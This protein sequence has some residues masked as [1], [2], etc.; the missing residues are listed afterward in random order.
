MTQEFLNLKNIFEVNGV[1]DRDSLAQILSLAN[2]GLNYVPQTLNNKNYYV[3]LKT[4][5]ES[6]LKYPENQ[7]VYEN[8]VE[9]IQAYIYDINIQKVS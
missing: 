1:I 9:K 5:V 7:S 4:A 2:K 8:L 6:S 3:D